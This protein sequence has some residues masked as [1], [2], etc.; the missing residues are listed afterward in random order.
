MK[1]IGVS[2]L[3]S[4]GCRYRCRLNLQNPFQVVGELEGGGIALGSEFPHRATADAVEFSGDARFGVPERW[5]VTAN[6]L[7][8]NLLGG[9]AAKGLMASQQFVEHHA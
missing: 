9:G 7:F 4:G 6:D 3:K 8:E 1:D 2:E 5:W